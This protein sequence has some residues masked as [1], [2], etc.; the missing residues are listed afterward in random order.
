MK[1]LFA[2]RGV[3]ACSIAIFIVVGLSIAVVAWQLLRVN[4]A[5]LLAPLQA[6][7]FATTVAAAAIG[8]AATARSRRRIERQLAQS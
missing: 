1:R 4:G 7:A 8:W 5:T 2:R 3:A 6:H